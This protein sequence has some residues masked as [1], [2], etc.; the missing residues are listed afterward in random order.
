MTTHKDSMST[1]QHL[2]NA[3]ACH[4]PTPGCRHAHWLTVTIETLIAIM[5]PEQAH[6]ALDSV[7]KQMNAGGVSSDA[8]TFALLQRLRGQ[9]GG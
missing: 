7:W 1:P 4:S 2:N 8:A 6:N 9:L 3:P 5:P